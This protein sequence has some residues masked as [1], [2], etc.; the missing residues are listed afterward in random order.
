M[1]SFWP[2]TNRQD[3]AGLAIFCEEPQPPAG[4]DV[5]GDVDL[6]RYRLRRPFW[7]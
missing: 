6:D 5:R 2:T 3:V 4:I 1:N 7:L